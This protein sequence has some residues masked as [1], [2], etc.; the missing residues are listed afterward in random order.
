[1][2]KTEYL[3]TVGKSRMDVQ[4]RVVSVTW[5]ALLERLAKTVRTSETVAEWKAMS[6]TVRGRVKDVGGFVGGVVG[7]PDGKG[8]WKDGPRRAFLVARRSML[9]LDIDYGTAGL[10]DKV[11]DELAGTAWA[12]Y[13]THSHTPEAPRWRLIVPLSRA[14]APDEYAPIARRI[15]QRIGMDLFDDSTYQPERLMY[16]P[17]TS[18]DGEFLSETGEGGALDV[19]AVLATYVDWHDARE[20]PLSSRVTSLT[21]RSGRKLEDPATKGGIVGAFCSCYGIEE[22]IDTFLPD[23]YE[24]TSAKDRWTYLGGSTTGGAIVYEDKWLYSHHG[25]DPCCEREVNAF[26][27]VR[28]HLFAD[29]DTDADADTPVNRLPS[30]MRMQ[31]LALT[32][33]K[34]DAEL[35]RRRIQEIGLEFQG[36]QTEGGQAGEDPAAWLADLQW[37]DE[38]RKDYH[39]PSPY[40]FGL[41]VRNDPAIRDAV[42]YNAFTDTPELVRPLPWQQDLTNHKDWTDTDDNGLAEYV[43]EHYRLVNKGALIDAHDLDNVKHSYHPVRDYLNALVWDGVPRVETLLVDYLG[44]E[45]TPLVRAMTRKHLAA[46]VARVMRPGVKYDY[47]LALVGPEGIGKSTLI[48][49]LGRGWYNDSFAS[50]DMGSKESMEQLRG[51]WLIEMGELKDYKKATVESFK[52]FVSKTAD[53]Y[54]PA[55]GRKKVRYLRQCVFFATTNERAFLKGDTGNRRFWTVD[56][57]DDMTSEDVFALD[58]ATVGQIW[59]EAVHIYNKGETLFLPAD[60]EMQ[61]REL[62][63]SHN[64]ITADDRTGL[65][66]AYLQT[67]LPSNWYTLTKTQRA[68]YFENNTQPLEGDAIR[69]QYVCSAE[70][71]TECLR[72]RDIT[73]YDTKEINQ[74]LANMPGLMYRGPIRTTDQAYGVQRRYMITDKF[75]ATK[76]ENSM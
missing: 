16:W 53:E 43:S 76:E 38:K 69:R 24:K 50:S 56:V 40:N 48:A 31:E 63:A 18:K 3:I 11:R 39:L 19:D 27:L 36:A 15:A 23:T 20:W 13:T 32:D 9:T 33:R 65:I 54:R 22:A 12:M 5:P 67:P 1:M 46:A 70:V 44:A 37:H 41:I 14:V 21:T 62:Q 52:A 30:F 55:Y 47:V 7:E 49:K 29:L 4:W 26:D 45:D 8:G 64:E 25:T 35:T 28:L 72:K 75:H 68:D 59:A 51:C 2:S 66:E 71:L 10:P 73:R 58:D 6:P 57:G 34:V 17:S 60:L 74:I 42:R 61:A